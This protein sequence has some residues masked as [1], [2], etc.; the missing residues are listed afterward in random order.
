MKI[1]Q[2][3]IFALLP[4]LIAMAACG[5][6]P[7]AQ[8]SNSDVAKEIAVTGYDEFTQNTHQQKQA[9]VK[10]GDTITLTLFSNATT[11]FSWDENAKIADT[12]VLQQTGHEYIAPKSDP[13]KPAMAGAGGTEQWTFKAL[14]AGTTTVHLEY[15]RPWA[16]GEKGVWIF[17]LSATVK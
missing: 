6:A 10:V 11:G 3:I 7:E 1:K 4:G 15:G 17:D 9:E 13:S 2:T 12:A 5:T 14:K 8:K 16:G